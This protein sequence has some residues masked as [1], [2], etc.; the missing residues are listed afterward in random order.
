MLEMKYIKI[1]IKLGKPDGQGHFL[2]ISEVTGVG[3]PPLHPHAPR[4][5]TTMVK[6]SR[7][8]AISNGNSV[9]LR[10]DVWRRI[11]SHEFGSNSSS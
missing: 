5:N 6:G 10:R 7:C 2:V 8:F 11:G 1:T 3:T 4:G 9:A